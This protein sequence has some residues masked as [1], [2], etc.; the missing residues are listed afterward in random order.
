MNKVRLGII[1][2]G[3]IGKYHA[4]YLL[5]GKVKGCELTALS[6]SDT[7]S[8]ER[9]QPLRLFDDGESLIRSGDVDAVIIAT[10]HLQ[11]T[12]LGITAF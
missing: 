6:S 2:M 7:K 9:Y 11:H 10:P 12:K 4:E 8:L 3:N 1:G 5:A